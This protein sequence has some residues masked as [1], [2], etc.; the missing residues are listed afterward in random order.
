MGGTPVQL[1][2]ENGILNNPETIIKYII[3]LVTHDV[4]NNDYKIVKTF[5]PREGHTRHSAKLF[6]TSDESKRRVMQ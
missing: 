6:F 5:Q 2:T 3:T 1:K 4:N